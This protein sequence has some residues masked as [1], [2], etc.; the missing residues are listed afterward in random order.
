MK[1][2]SVED[3][4]FYEYTPDCVSYYG[5]HFVE[6]GYLEVLVV[7]TSEGYDVWNTHPLR[8]AWQK[9]YT[10]S[11]CVPEQQVVDSLNSLKRLFEK[12]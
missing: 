8:K 3:I 1:Y 6:E 12:E 11:S 5:I 4:K 10:L 9:C 2:N 7:P